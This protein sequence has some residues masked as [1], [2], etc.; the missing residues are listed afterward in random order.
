MKLKHNK[1]M[2]YKNSLKHIL[3]PAV[4]ALS[5]IVGIVTHRY[6]FQSAPV[7]QKMSGQPSK[8]DKLLRKITIDYVDKVKYDSLQ[9]KAIPQI[10][11]NLDPHSSYIPAR[12]KKEVDAPIMGEFDG[13]G[14]QFNIRRDTVMVIQTIAGCPSEKVGIMGGD[15]IVKVNDT[16]SAGVDISTR[17]VMK[18]LKGKR[19]TRVNVSVKRPGT[20]ELIDFEI[21]RDKI[22]LY[23]VDISYMLNNKTG[24]IKVN[25][26][27]RNTYSEFMQGANKL[28]AKGMKQLIV[29]LRGN[30]GGIMEAA[31]RMA[32]EFLN[33]GKLIVYTQGN[34]RPKREYRASRQ[35]FLTNIK[36]AVLIDEWSASAS[37][38]FA[39]ALQDNDKGVIVG[40]RSFGKGLVQEP[41]YFDD[42]S[43]L[44]L[45]VARYY[46]PTGR[47]IQKPYKNGDEESYREDITRRYLNGEFLEEDSIQFADSLKFT[48]P[49]G[50]TVY[51]GG[52]IMPD[53]FVSVDTSAGSDFL[54][55]VRRKGLQYSFAYDFTD[56]NRERLK[57]F[58]GYQQ[59]ET[60]LSNQN[61][62]DN[63]VK[64]AQKKRVKAD[65]EDLKLSGKMLKTQITGLVARNILGDQGFYPIIHEVD[66]TLKKALEELQN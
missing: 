36:V 58:E 28:K 45:T 48:T 54:Y 59:L 5:I 32:D 20:D 38:I 12:L 53:V 62:L 11:E 40:R 50:K 30:G 56:K 49:G 25:K 26:F 46:T 63:F 27:S 55:D 51:G 42:G 64:F 66:T 65:P 18:K 7:V 61:L 3:Y 37:E 19:G 2:N 31:I 10:V 47:S 14:V 34:N 23:S 9:E 6:F 29:D 21:I 41:V 13:I 44:R 22:P 60:Y 43:E 16:V 4:I 35:N 17:E 57:Q 24:Y 8:I 15:R 39:G 1:I 33:A 52:G